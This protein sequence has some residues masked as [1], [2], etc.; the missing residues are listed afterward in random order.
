[1]DRERMM[2]ALAFDDIIMSGTQHI[3]LDE[4]KIANKN[5]HQTETKQQTNTK[6][7]VPMDIPFH[8]CPTKWSQTNKTLKWC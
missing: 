8:Q 1:M 2:K 6:Q 3:N 4:S 7:K 5:K